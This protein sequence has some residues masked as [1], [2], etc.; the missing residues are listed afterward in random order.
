MG[1]GRAGVQPEPGLRP[2]QLRR[3]AGARRLHLLLELRATEV[4]DEVD[5]DNPQPLYVFYHHQNTERFALERSGWV[6][7]GLVPSA[8]GVSYE[9]WQALPEA[10]RTRRHRELTEEVVRTRVL[11]VFAEHG[12]EVVWDGSAATNLQLVGA[13]F[14]CELD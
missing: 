9:E 2:A 7:F 6:G 14:Y 10:E 8:L 5:R 13:D 11:P 4:W 3:A 1:P 12:I